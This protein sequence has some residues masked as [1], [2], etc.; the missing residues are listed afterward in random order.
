MSRAETIYFRDVA[1]GGSV[2]ELIRPRSFLDAAPAD[3]DNRLHARGVLRCHRALFV[4][5]QDQNPLWP[6][7]V[8]NG[9]GR[10]E[11]TDVRHKGRVMRVQVLPAA[12]LVLKPT[13]NI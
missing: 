4:S 5:D 8:V 3:R 11:T 13:V 6:R 9:N 12:S 10:T 7:R 1:D 2:G